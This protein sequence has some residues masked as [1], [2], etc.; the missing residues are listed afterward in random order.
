[1]QKII[2]A[3]FFFLIFPQV[4]LSDGAR[5]HSGRTVIHGF[6][7]TGINDLLGSPI[8]PGPNFQLIGEHVP[9][10]DEP[11]PV[12]SGT[13]EHAILATRY[14]LDLLGLFG[15][16]PGANGYPD[17]QDNVPLNE[18]PVPVAFSI[19]N[20]FPVAPASVATALEPSRRDENPITLGD[21]LDARG[22]AFIRCSRDGSRASVVLSMKGLVDNGLYTLWAVPADGSLP[23][24]FGGVPNVFSADRRGSA[25]VHRTVAYC[26]TDGQLLDITVAY[27]SDGMAYGNFPDATLDGFVSGIVAHDHVV[28]PLLQE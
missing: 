15:I 27:H 9:G 18:N 19:Y 21:W 1:M 13:P 16:V 17:D 7:V 24:A 12:T 8:G 6:A 28:F 23:N 5:K 14:P 2:C 10:G 26:P 20:R 3:C 25:L 11:L 4:A 22:K